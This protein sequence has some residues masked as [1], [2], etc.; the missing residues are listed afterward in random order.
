MNTGGPQTSQKWLCLFVCSAAGDVPQWDRKLWR[1]DTC[2]CPHVCVGVQ[3]GACLRLA[4]PSRLCSWVTPCSRCHK[5][6]TCTSSRYVRLVCC[7]LL[8]LRTVLT[9]S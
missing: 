1:P 7:A 9:V 8:P 4:A 3:G 2:V 5:Q 6:T